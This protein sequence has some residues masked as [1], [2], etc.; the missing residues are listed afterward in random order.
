[1]VVV[2]GEID[3][4]QRLR[5][6]T[7]SGVDHQDRTFARGQRTADFVRKVDVSGGVHQIE[8]IGFA[9]GSGIVQPHRL[10]FDRN[11]ALAFDIH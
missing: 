3:V 6:H 1:M 8:L 11:A 2:N 4:G 10:G 7:L 9:V 5:F